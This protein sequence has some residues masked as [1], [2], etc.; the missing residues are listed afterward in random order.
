MK[1][2][3]KY[4]IQIIYL[5]ILINSLKGSETDP[6]NTTTIILE[7]LS[8]TI[9]EAI[10][11]TIPTTVPTTITPAIPEVTP[12]AI[13]ETTISSTN[14]IFN[15]NEPY[16][17]FD[18]TTASNLDSTMDIET[19][20][21]EVQITEIID[22]INPLP[23]SLEENI[24]NNYDDSDK[25]WDIEPT[26]GIINDCILG[27]QLKND[28][29]CYMTVEYKYNTLYACIPVLKDK[30]EIERRIEI[31]KNIYTENKSIKINCFVSF[32]KLNLIF[33]LLIFL[34]D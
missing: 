16:N 9:F 20:I 4:F 11:T 34:F 29:C 15:N 24:N 27:V 19:N 23:T 13:Q 14:P 17:S 1:I 8:P 2:F 21:E 25:C 12:S 10:P 7:T 32:I 18:W 28:T 3:G 31:L 5:S 6:D 26:K 30:N 33:L 22:P